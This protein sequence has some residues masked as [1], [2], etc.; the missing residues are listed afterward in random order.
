MNNAPDQRGLAKR[1]KARLP[2]HVFELASRALTQIATRLPYRLKYGVAT[3]LAKRRAPY[4]Y[5]EPH[6]FVVQ[7]GSARDILGTGRS[8]AI[9][10]ARTVTRGRVLVIEADPGNCDAL[11]SFIDRHEVHNIDVVD[12]GAWDERGF[13][14]FLSSARHPAANLVTEVKHISHEDAAKRDYASMTIPVDTVDNILRNLECP[15]P[16]LVSITT[17]GSELPILQGMKETL[18]TGCRYISLAST[19]P[20]LIETMAALDYRYVARDDRGYCFQKNG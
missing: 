6:D 16:Q 13:L 12:S 2:Q 10:L 4:S 7:I 11:R 19:G 15:A 18:A 8:R 5:L 1:L 3:P 9:L 17:N 20:E 14:S